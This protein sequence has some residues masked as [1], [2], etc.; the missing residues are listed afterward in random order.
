MK[1]NGK[2]GNE[3]V[4]RY[5]RSM[6]V[7]EFVGALEDGWSKVLPSVNEIVGGVRAG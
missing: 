4:G 6:V 5:S 2:L 7:D 1:K 3:P